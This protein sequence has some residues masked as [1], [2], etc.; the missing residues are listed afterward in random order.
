MS[1]TKSAMDGAFCKVDIENLESYLKDLAEL[2][3]YERNCIEQ[4]YGDAIQRSNKYENRNDYFI[5]TYS[6][7]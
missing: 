6:Q 3:P 5:K 1:K 4:A 2:L 7:Q